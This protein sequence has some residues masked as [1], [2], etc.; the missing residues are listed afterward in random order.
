[1]IWCSHHA[2]GVAQADILLAFVLN[3]KC[4]DVS[5][6]WQCHAGKHTQNH[7]KRQRSSAVPSS[8]PYPCT[9]SRSVWRMVRTGAFLLAISAAPWYQQ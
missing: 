1:M 8:R 9:R 3:G 5:E 2:I 4:I 7:G 6:G